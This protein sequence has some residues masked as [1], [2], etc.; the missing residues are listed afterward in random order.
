MNFCFRKLHCQYTSTCY[1]YYEKEL[2]ENFQSTIENACKKIKRIQ[3]PD[4][5]HEVLPEHEEMNMGTTLF[6]V[7]LVLKRFAMLSSVLCPDVTDFKINQYHDWFTPGVAHWLDISAYKAL[8]RIEKAIELDRLV[9]VDDTVKYSTSAVDALAIFYQI[10]IFWQQLDWPDVEGSYTFVAKIVDDICRCCIFYADCMSSRVDNLG[11]VD[12]VYE[13]RFEVT[14]EWCLAINNIDY[15]RQSLSPFV[16]ELK[17]D[18]VIKKLAE[19]R[20]PVEAERCEET[21]K[22]VVDNAIDNE[23]NKILDLIEIVAQKM[24]PQMRK[25]LME[26]AEV[27]HQDSNSMDRLMMYLEESL[28]TLNNELNEVNF[29]RVLN[30]IWTEL[31][32]ILYELVQSNLEV[33]QSIPETRTNSFNTVTSRFQKRRPPQFFANLRETLRIMVKS[34]KTGASCNTEAET[35]NNIDEMLKVHSYETN[36]LIHQYYVERHKHQATMTDAPYGQLT[37]KCCFKDEI[38]LEV[39]T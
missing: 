3:L 30:S 19:Y 16:K 21:L 15:I 32:K 39:R 34:F 27:L 14:R 4:H 8:K 38:M 11:N 25:F 13:K 24:G 10:K 18:E 35:L 23:T 7:Y 31:A 37:V 6:E 28:K 12:N 17:V 26:G 29:E 20:S 22:N 5:P 33:R 9:P 36:D 2:A 1:V